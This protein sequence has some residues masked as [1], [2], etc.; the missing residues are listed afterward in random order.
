[1]DSHASTPERQHRLISAVLIVAAVWLVYGWSL[2]APFIFDDDVTVVQNP[3]IRQLWPPGPMLH[4]LRYSPT[5]GRPLVNV[6]FAINY[7]FGELNPFGYHLFNVALHAL[8][9]LLVWA[10]VGRTLA[11]PRFNFGRFRPALA[12][13]VG[14]IWAVHPLNSEAVIYITQ[15]T[16]LMMGLF[17]LA[18]IYAALRYWQAAPGIGGEGCET[19]PNW[20]AA[21]W[22]WLIA[23]GLSC[24]AGMACKEVMVSAPLAVLLYQWTLMG[25]GW[26]RIRQSWPLYVAVGAGWLVLLALN[27]GGPRSISAGFGLN[28]S[29]FDWWLSQC[30]VLLMYLKLAVWPWPL[31]LHYKTVYLSGALSTIVFGGA[32]LLLVALAA[33]GLWRRWT[34]GYV[35]AWML[36]ILAPTSLVPIITEAAAERRVYLPLAAIAALLV[37]AGFSL[38]HRMRL[39]PASAGALGLLLVLVLALVNLH[40]LAMYRD[41]ALLWQDLIAHQGDNEVACNNLAAIWQERGDPRK[42]RQLFE[43]A[44]QIDPNFAMAR[45]NL[46]S[47]LADVGQYD[48]AIEQYRIALQNQPTLALAES[49][50]GAALAKLGRIDEAIGHYEQALRLDPYNIDA[51]Y[52]MAVRLLH[53]G[54]TEQAIEHLRVVLNMKRDDVEANVNMGM[55]LVRLERYQQAITHYQRALETDPTLTQAWV[56]LAQ[57]YMNLDRMDDAIAAAQRAYDLARAQGDTALAERL[58]RLLAPDENASG[59]RP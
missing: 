40:R 19:I 41:P 44:L 48:Q 20:S 3:T 56:N 22:G 30:R 34:V 32:V 42:A 28:V 39:K 9:S 57:A 43:R 45:N 1:M 59:A 23:A 36:M 31:L 37:A 53:Q 49:N 17:Y 5:A 4:P 14:L 46:G 10:I 15:R 21:K 38:L 27:V 16:E 58:G 13:I 26:K 18:T 2:N 7:R 52:N 12:A 11:L 35:L 25:A 47:L 54:R 24:A 8:S 51:N 29:L 6:T 33:V 55:A 50:W